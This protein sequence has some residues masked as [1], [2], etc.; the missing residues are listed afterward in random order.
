MKVGVISDTHGNLAGLLEAY[1]RLRADPGIAK[2]FFLGHQYGDIDRLIGV[3][4]A[5]QKAKSKRRAQDDDDTMDEGLLAGALLS[6]AL[7]GGKPAPRAPATR[8]KLEDPEWIRKHVV[9]IAA[10]DD[11]EAM[12]GHAS[13]TDFEMVAGRF[14]CAVHDPRQL[15]KDD[16][17]SASIV[18][19][20]HTHIAQA[21]KMSGR[22]FLNPG[23]LMERD[24]QGRAPSYGVLDL[25]DAP[26]FRV[27][28]LE[29]ALRQ[30]FP[31]D[32]EV[33][34]KFSVS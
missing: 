22:Y 9:R 4:E 12:Q 25:G 23:H 2:I 8:D 11:D 1:D 15:Q 31:L 14:I 21:D 16:I 19:Y 13:K 28:D 32:L 29:G 30:E 20:G 33:K 27:Y 7:A 17:A 26:C 5:L 3:K 6:D 24:D 34:R 10:A 18:L